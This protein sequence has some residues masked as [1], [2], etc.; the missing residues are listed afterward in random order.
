MGVLE[1]HA[2]DKFRNLVPG[3]ER[4]RPVG[5]G[6]ASVVAGDEG[7]GD[8]QEKRPTG[9]DYGEAVKPG[10]VIGG[11]GFQSDAPWVLKLGRK[12]S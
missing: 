5:N 7:A 9:Q 6:E 2:T 12:L 1:F 11:D 4:G 8:D 10:I 3:A